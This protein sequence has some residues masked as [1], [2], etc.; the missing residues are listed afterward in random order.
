MFILKKGMF[1][2]LAV[3]M[4][5]LIGCSTEKEIEGSVGVAKNSTEDHAKTKVVKDKLG[6]VEIPTNPLRIADVSGSTEELLF[7][8]FKPV[9]SSNIDIENPNAFSPVIINQL[10]PDTVNAGWYASEI[11]IE[12]VASAN[13]DLI[14]AGARH[15]KLVDQLKKIA[16][17]VMVPYDFN[18]FQDRFEFIAGIVD[19]ETE[20]DAWFIDYEKTAK[21]WSERIR[22]ITKDETFAIIEATPKEIRIYAA[23]GVADM[24]FNDMLLPKAEG[25]PEPDAWGEKVTSVEALASFDPDHIILMVDSTQ[26]IVDD[27]NVW[28]S[29]KAVK[30]NHVYRMTS[31][32]NYNYAFTAMGKR[33]LIDELGELIVK[34]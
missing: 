16:P 23:T 21:D 15:E 2:L 32:K 8:G 19:K 26:S 29:M 10:E 12:A 5:L 6:E 31:A 22:T 33:K 25:T 13:P 3:M 27:N 11:N 7:F 18:A 20:M 17:T 30:N 14:I 28:A 1:T 9:V 34:E 4:S 24:I